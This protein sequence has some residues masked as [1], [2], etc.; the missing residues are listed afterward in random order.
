M[1]PLLS[2]K[3]FT[4]RHLFNKKIFMYLFDNTINKR[5][6][7][8]GFTLVELLIVIAILGILSVAVLGAINVTSS[9]NK[10]NLAKAKTF[11]ASVEN[12]L[13]I[14][15]VGKWS[16][17][18]SSSPS[19][20]TSGYGNDG[21]WNGGVTW[22]DANTCALGFKGCLK[23]DG[24]VN[25]YVEATSAFGDKDFKTAPF[26]IALWVNP[27][28]LAGSPVFIS[29][30]NTTDAN[31]K[32]LVF[33]TSALPIFVSWRNSLGVRYGLRQT[34]NKILPLNTWSHIVITHD[35]TEPSTT[36]SRIYLNSNI[37][38]VTTDA[39][40]W[41]MIEA[42]KVR[43]GAGGNAV[44]GEQ[45]FSGLIDEVAIYNQAFTLS[46][47]QQLYAQGLPRHQ[48]AKRY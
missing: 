33:I 45:Y 6:S 5:L 37:L 25:T 48:L 22:Q 29:I 47:I 27:S 35:G 2:T 9:L 7:G 16:F 14:N 41:T 10:A 38:P 13:S 26:T 42:N 39:G 34:N 3:G 8:A 15:Q 23:F 18:E 31:F 46:Q 12:T 28:S 11:S 44:G 4:Q 32:I 24:S 36:S 17:E 19:K 21:V 20:D 30:G 1:K 40:S 43:I